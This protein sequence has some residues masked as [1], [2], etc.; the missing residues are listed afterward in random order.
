MLWGHAGTLWS[1]CSR[2][3]LHSPLCLICH[4]CLM[5]I[6][7]ISQ[8]ITRSWDVLLVTALSPRSP[9]CSSMSK[10]R[11]SG[12]PDTGVQHWG[13]SETS[14]H[15]RVVLLS[16]DGGRASQVGTRC[17]CSN[18]QANLH[19]VGQPALLWP[20]GLFQTFCN[21]S[22]TTNYMKQL[23]SRQRFCFTEIIF[24]LI[25]WK[26]EPENHQN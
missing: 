19:H 14:T 18:N 16:R 2:R 11:S 17:L 6:S 4:L 3:P 15:G 23:R 1:C 10:D 20:L 5:L 21:Y 8:S 12:C 25:F 13:G 22:C 7:Q 26:L 24:I 9:S